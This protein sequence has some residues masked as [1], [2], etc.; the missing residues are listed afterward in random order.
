[1]LDAGPAPHKSMRCM[2][3]GIQL[4]NFRQGAPCHSMWSYLLSRV[5]FQLDFHLN[6]LGSH[7]HAS[8]SINSIILSCLHATIP[9]LCPLCR[10][11]YQPAKIK[12]LHVDR[13]ENVDEAREMELGRQQLELLE[14]LVD[15]WDLELQEGFIPNRDL[16]EDSGGGRGKAING[17]AL[18]E[19][20]SVA[21]RRVRISAGLELVN[22]GDH[23]GDSINENGLTGPGDDNALLDRGDVEQILD[24]IAGTPGVGRGF[25]ERWGSDLGN[26]DPEGGPVVTMREVRRLHYE[27][28]M[29]QV[30][31]W[32]ASRDEETVSRFVFHG[33]V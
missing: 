17:E 25:L 24:G 10:K 23:D 33:S 3:A 6:C 26:N 28:V 11:L 19:S 5:S 22:G 14:K 4:G 32:L 30:D 7:E 18:I 8:L 29:R 2:F 9:P 20:S 15:I 16:I 1:M 12:K 21:Q 13:P 27:D 31:V